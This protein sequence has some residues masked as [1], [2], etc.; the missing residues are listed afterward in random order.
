MQLSFVAYDPA[1]A[2]T[3]AAARHGALRSQVGG[4]AIHR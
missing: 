3:Q 2:A 1:P 4:H